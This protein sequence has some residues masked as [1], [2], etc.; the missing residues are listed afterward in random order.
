MA[1]GDTFLLC[2]GGYAPLKIKVTDKVN[3]FLNEDNNTNT[4]IK[5]YNFKKIFIGKDSP[6]MAQKDADKHSKDE[7]PYQRHHDYGNTVLLNIDGYK[8]LLLS[9]I[10]FFTFETEDE[11]I[12][13]Y[14][15]YDAGV[16]YPFAIGTKNVYNLR[17]W[18]YADKEK[19]DDIYDFCSEYLNCVVKSTGVSYISTQSVNKFLGKPYDTIIDSKVPEHQ[20]I[21]YD[22]TG[23][24]LKY[25]MS[26]FGI[27]QNEIDNL[28]KY[29]KINF[30]DV[31]SQ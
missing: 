13:Y 4:P 31:T 8:Y 17:D 15:P 16:P 3:V 12:D 28:R 23:D 18:V 7:M 30:S 26:L 22:D 14:S 11:I 29:K 6:S 9:G 25:K 21:A 24:I 5:S 1:N 2:C 27:T 19:I 20:Q 10:G